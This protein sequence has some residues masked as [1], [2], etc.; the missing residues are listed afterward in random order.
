MKTHRSEPATKRPKGPFIVNWVGEGGKGGR[1]E[2]G[3]GG[4]GEGGKGGRGEGGKGG[5]GEGVLEVGGIWRS[6]I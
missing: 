1:G 5:R 4:R 6:V 3:K 2:G